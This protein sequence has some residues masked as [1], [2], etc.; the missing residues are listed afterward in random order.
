MI[1]NQTQSSRVYVQTDAD[2][3]IVR[4]EGGYTTPTD[5]TG[6]VQIDDGTGDR[7]NLCQSHYLPGGTYTPDG[8]PRYRLADGIPVLR[9][10]DEIQADRAAR[11]TATQPSE[12]DTLREQNQ[13]LAAQVEAQSGQMEFLESCLAEMAAAVY[14]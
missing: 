14:A 7:Y 10:E 2:G 9:G 6:W 1:G 4:C 11:V 13:R 3:R 5:L 12:L 8:L